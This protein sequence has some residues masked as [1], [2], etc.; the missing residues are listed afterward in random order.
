MAHTDP[1]GL[2]GLSAQCAP[3]VVH[4]GATHHHWNTAPLLFKELVNGKQCSF[5]IQSVEDG[6]N[7]QQV[8]T[9]SNQTTHLVIVCLH[10]LIKRGG[11]VSRV[12]HRRRNTQSAV[13]GPN[14]SGSKTGLAGV[15]AGKLHTGSLCKLSCSLVQPEHLIICIQGV[16]G[17]GNESSRERVCLN[18]VCA[19]SQ[20][21]LMDIADDIRSSHNQD[22]VVSLQVMRVVLENCATE[23]RLLQLTPLDHGSHGS[24]NHHD[25]FFHACIQH[26]E[27]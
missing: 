27:G 18:D 2:V 6:L 13:G 25:A 14:G 15:L 10:H 16:V 24:V 4:N 22:V 1:E 23:V 12:L 11:T 20:V 26:I 5:G 8:H 9:S 19:C 17:L 21:L 3:A 7:Q